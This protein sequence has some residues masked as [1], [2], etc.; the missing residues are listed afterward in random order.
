MPS[1]SARFLT[2]RFASLA[3]NRAQRRTNA[4]L[5]LFDTREEGNGNQGHAYGTQ[6]SSQ[7]KEKLLEYLNT[8]QG[9]CPTLTRAQFCVLTSR[10]KFFHTQRRE[11]DLNQAED[12]SR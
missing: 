8:H 3:T 2:R 9:I 11:T 12:F 5:F 6:L 4:A 1:F 7:D 10:P